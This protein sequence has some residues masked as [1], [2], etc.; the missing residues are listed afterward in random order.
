MKNICHRTTSIV[1]RTK[2]ANSNNIK[3]TLT[4]TRIVKLLVII[5]KTIV[6]IAIIKQ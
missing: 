4:K 6:I 3:I 1:M 2:V 5:I